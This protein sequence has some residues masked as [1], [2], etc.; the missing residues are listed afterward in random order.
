M[1]L[2]TALDSIARDMDARLPRVLVRELEDRRLHERAM[3]RAAELVGVPRLP[4]DYKIALFGMRSGARDAM[5]VGDLL[6][7]ARRTEGAI[8]L[9]I[10]NVH[11]LLTPTEAAKVLPQVLMPMHLSPAGDPMAGASFGDPANRGA[12]AGGPGASVRRVP[13]VLYGTTAMPSSDGGG[14]ADSDPARYSNGTG[15]DFVVSHV[16]MSEGSEPTRLAPDYL[17]RFD[18]QW[19]IKWMKS[20]VPATAVFDYIG[21]PII[22]ATS[23]QGCRWHFGGTYRLGT[24]QSIYVSVQNFNAS[25]AVRAAV[26]I[27]GHKINSIGS[28]RLFFSEKALA[29]G[30]VETPLPSGDFQNDGDFMCDLQ[31]VSVT[32][33]RGDWGVANPTA[34]GF[35][36]RPSE[37]R[38]FTPF[39]TL[40]TAA[41]TQAGQQGGFLRLKNPQ[42][43]PNG[44]ALNFNLQNVVAAARTANVGFIGWLEVPA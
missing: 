17:I 35:F 43:I 44:T 32:S 13:Y 31:A 33:G 24:S 16:T 37:D 28:P 27:Y 12:G 21:A 34:P 29:A 26:V 42:R 9:P 22:T 14:T 11:H 30:A 39:M 19:G 6:A 23:F 18:P 20:L 4:D 5:L 15:Y 7:R 1:H 2:P 36:I 40:A 38:E 3:D 8:A 25:E 10:G 41:N